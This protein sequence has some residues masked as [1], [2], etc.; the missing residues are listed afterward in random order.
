MSQAKLPARERK[1]DL[2]VVHM[3]GEHEVERV[4]RQTVKNRGKVA[5]EDTEIGVGIR[6]TPGRRLSPAEASWIDAHQL[7]MAP[8][9]LERLRLVHEEAR[10]REVGEAGGAREGIPAVLD[11]V[12]AEDH[13]A[14]LE[15]KQQLAE[16][17]LTARPGDEV[18]RDD[19]EVRRERHRPLDRALGR[20]VAAGRDAEVKVGQMDDAQPVQ[21][22]R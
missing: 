11:V 1:R 6:E 15:S 19:S 17:R 13:V 8:A 20:H 3:A 21:L 4:T 7:D 18:S 9:E 5:E 22:G 10:R 2:T 16:Q 14:P 12:I